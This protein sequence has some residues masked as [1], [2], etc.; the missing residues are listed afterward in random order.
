MC[1]GQH[2]IEHILVNL[3]FIHSSPQFSFRTAQSSHF[4]QIR[5]YNMQNSVSGFCHL[6]SRSKWLHVSLVGSFSLLNSL[7]GQTTLCSSVYLLMSF[8]DVSSM[9]VVMNNAAMKYSLTS[10]VKCLRCPISSGS[11]TNLL[12]L[13]IK[14]FNGNS[15]KCTGNVDSWFRLNV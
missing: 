5:L 7:Y 9:E 15:H 14:T 11:E 12:L 1:R 6:A 2:I 13:A 10:S 8:P 4:I 3:Q